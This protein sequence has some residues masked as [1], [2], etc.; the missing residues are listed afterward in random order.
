MDAL[1]N[2]IGGANKKNPENEKVIE[3]EKAGIADKLHGM[4]GGG[5]SSE[6]NE[7]ALD[8]TIDLVQEKVFGAGPQNN[9][10][11]IEQ[12]KDEAISDGQYSLPA[13]IWHHLTF[14]QPFAASIRA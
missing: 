2:L 8:K 11:A 10:N 13:S 9:E 1:N 3:E 14:L 6:A 7:D 12:A 4:L 5:K